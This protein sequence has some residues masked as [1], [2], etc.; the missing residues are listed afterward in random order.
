MCCNRLFITEKMG[1]EIVFT[2]CFMSPVSKIVLKTKLQTASYAFQSSTG[3]D[4]IRNA[5]SP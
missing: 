2:A 1:N 5:H 3:C 4:V